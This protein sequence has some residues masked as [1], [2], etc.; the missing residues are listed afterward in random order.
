MFT[1]FTMMF[2]WL[3]Y[4]SLIF[5]IHSCISIDHW[6]WY[7]MYIT[8]VSQVTKTASL[9]SE[10]DLLFYL[11]SHLHCLMMYPYVQTRLI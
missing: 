10:H 2:Q 11:N 7:R 8:P 9:I 4:V 3:W 5:Y 1:K 6:T